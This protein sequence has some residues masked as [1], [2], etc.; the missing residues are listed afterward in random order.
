VFKVIENVA[1]PLVHVVKAMVVKY[2]RTA[3]GSVL[4]KTTGPAKR[5][6]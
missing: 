1:A 4:V 2:G 6:G 5:A 3:A